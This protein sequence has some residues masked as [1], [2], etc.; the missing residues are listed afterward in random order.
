MFLST[1]DTGKQSSRAK[2]N[3]VRQIAT[4]LFG[5]AL[6]ISA[7]YPVSA[8]DIL[9]FAAASLTLPLSDTVNS[10]RAANPQSRNIRLSF[11]ASSTLA[12]QIARGAPADIYI[13]A[14]PQWMDFLRDRK[15]VETTFTNHLAGNRLVMVSPATRQLADAPYDQF[16]PINI[17]QH[18]RI[19]IA[20]PDHV[21]AGIYAKAALNKLG[22]WEKLRPM[23]ARMVNVRSALALAERAEV[24]A[25][26]V[27]ATDAHANPR[28]ARVFTFPVDSHPLIRYP[29]A[30]VAGR[31]SD[32]IR[33]FFAYLSS[34]AA[35]TIFVRHGFL[36]G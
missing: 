1:S 32:E 36:V 3:V 18:G 12:Q 29:A 2:P 22:V 16:P 5:L 34:K 7:A 26:I 28:V 33:K 31:G 35:R 10:Y 23:L 20:D 6:G 24:S 19:A 25:A 11:A 4:I 30:I 13:S 15:H 27:Y 14:N 21:P 17:L 9:V 8:K